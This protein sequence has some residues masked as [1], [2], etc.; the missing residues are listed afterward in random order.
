MKVRV[1]A[2][3]RAEAQKLL[4]ELRKAIDSSHEIMA[5][6][7][8]VRLAFERAYERRPRDESL[9]ERVYSFA[10]WCASAPRGADAGQDP[11]TAVITAFYEDIPTHLAAREDMPRWF[12]YDEVVDGKAVFSY[13]LGEEGYRELLEHM[14]R[15]RGRYRVRNLE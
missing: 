15:N 7:I 14:R 2:R 4:P 3:W 13:H 8:E 6:W 12:T 11:L 9:I 1:M 5:L 10:D